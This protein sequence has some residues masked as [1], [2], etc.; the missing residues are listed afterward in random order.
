M[1][2]YRC[3]WPPSL[4]LVGTKPNQC[5]I[6]FV[7]FVVIR[8]ISQYAG[9]SVYLATKLALSR[10]QTKPMPDLFRQFRRNSQYAGVLQMCYRCCFTDLLQMMSRYLSARFAV[11]SAVRLSPWQMICL[12][13][14]FPYVFHFDRWCV[15][16]DV[17]ADNLSALVQCSFAFSATKLSS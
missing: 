3:I 16:D 11:L 2:V 17:G 4:L 12:S 9:V 6:Y 8:F 10:N 1:P 15:A 14:V 7:N 13:Y 5:R